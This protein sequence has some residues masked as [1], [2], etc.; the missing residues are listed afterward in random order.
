MAFLLCVAN[1]KGGSGKTTTAMNLAGGLSLAQYPV[2]V[3][4]A[5]RQESAVTWSTIGGRL[6]FE[7]VRAAD[8]GGRTLEHLMHG[9]EYEVVIVDCPPGVADDDAGTGA[10]FARLALRLCDAILVPVRPSTLDFS[11]TSSFV[12]FLER[13]RALAN[14]GQRVLVVLNGLQRTLLSR[15]A[16][17]EAR[18]LFAELPGALVLTSS[19]GLRIP[20]AEVSGSGQTIFDYAPHSEAAREFTQLTKEVI[21]CLAAPLSPPSAVPATR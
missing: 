6:P 9:T 19:I 4:D 12:V 17:G 14:P 3:V 5:D 21:A 7:V 15:Q 16:P 1:Q 8:L 11:S 18:K 2:L 10:L 20:I 13:L